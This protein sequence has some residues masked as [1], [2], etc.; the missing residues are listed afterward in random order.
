MFKKLLIN[1]LSVI[2]SISLITLILEL[3]IF[4]ILDIKPPGYKSQRFFRFSP[5]FGHEHQ[6]GVEGNYY[7]YNDGSKYYVSINSH[8]FS[9]KERNI[10]KES[11]RVALIGNSTTEFWET[12]PENRGH[13]VIEELLDKKFEVMNFGVRGYGTDQTCL[14]LE[15]K[16]INYRPDFVVYTFCINDIANNMEKEGKPYFV[17]DSLSNN[18]SIKGYPLEEHDIF[19]SPAEKHGIFKIDQI[20]KDKSFFYRKLRSILKLI[21]MPKVPLDR[22]IDL[23]PFQINRSEKWEN[24]WNMTLRIIERMKVFCELHNV[25]FILVD[26]IYRA[27]I[28]S[29]YQKRIKGKYG[30]IFNFFKVTND[31]KVFCEKNEIRFISLSEEALERHI[32]PENLMH[33]EDLMHP[34]KAGTRFFSEM[35]A[36]EVKNIEIEFSTSFK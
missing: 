15:K 20:I 26:G 31:L 33:I 2:I 19:N 1:I 27:S 10:K 16:I 8:G 34:N 13:V 30:D 9:D 36:K 7:R 28:D 23:L 5:L 35:V 6:P 14:L 25:N 18:L 4:Y 21:Y 32:D 12:I 11:S 24:G 17:F 3:S 29:D 22:H